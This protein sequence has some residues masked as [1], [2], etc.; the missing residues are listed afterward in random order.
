MGGRDQR[1][2]PGLLR[3]CVLERLR[4]ALSVR[5]PRAP[6]I[7]GV[8]YSAG[9]AATVVPV[10]GLFMVPALS[11]MVFVLAEHFK[12][13]RASG[14]GRDPV[15]TAEAAHVPIDPADVDDALIRC[16]LAAGH[17]GRAAGDPAVGRRSGCRSTWPRSGG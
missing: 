3:L 11:G 7:A 12:A 15:R 17:R 6:F 4:A 14:A 16:Q 9:I 8:G 2:V 10:A 5:A 1:L 13:E